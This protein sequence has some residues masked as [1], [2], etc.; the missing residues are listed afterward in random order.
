MLSCNNTFLS[1]SYPYGTLLWIIYDPRLVSCRGH[2]SD[3]ILATYG[4][5]KLHNNLKRLGD[6]N[7]ENMK[8][9]LSMSI[10][11]YVSLGISVAM[12]IW[13]THPLSSVLKFVEGVCLR[14]R[15]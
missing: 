8:L 6:V 10:T 14:A 13:K 7:M 12:M 5:M 2:T 11:V 15:E 3:R 4:C 9:S 1:T